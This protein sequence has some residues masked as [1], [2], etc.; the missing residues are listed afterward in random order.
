MQVLLCNCQRY[1]EYNLK[2][3]NLIYIIWAFNIISYSTVFNSISQA[4][5][6]F[7]AETVSS[8]VTLQSWQ[9]IAFHVQQN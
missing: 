5:L 9:N 6:F 7:L 4:G 1:F 8:S 3:P 2:E